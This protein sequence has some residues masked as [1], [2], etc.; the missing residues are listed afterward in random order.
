MF[1]DTAIF[2]E[3]S[4]L[5]AITIAGAHDPVVYNQIVCQAA[6]FFAN[7]ALIAVASTPRSYAGRRT[8]FWIV[9]FLCMLVFS[10]TS[11]TSLQVMNQGRDGIDPKL[12]GLLVYSICEPCSA[13]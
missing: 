5:V 6:S 12:T 7:S 3:L 1:L 2:F 11:Y 13:S 9:L 8:S 10:V 4:L